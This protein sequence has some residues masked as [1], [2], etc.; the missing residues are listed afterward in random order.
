VAELEMQGQV[1]PLPRPGQLGDPEARSRC[2]AKFAHHELMAVELFAWALLRWPTLPRA[3][4]K[5]LL[6]ILTEE[7]LHC[8]LYLE[9]LEAHGS[10]LADHVLSDYFW[11]HAPAISASAE[12][13]SAFL[14]AMGLTLEQGNLD[15]GPLYRDAFRDAGDLESARVCEQVHRDEVAHVRF[16]AHW[17]R[18]LSDA[19]VDGE[20]GSAPGAAP[21][22][23]ALYERAVPFLLSAARAK[24]RRF[25]A[26]ARREAGLSEDF[27]EHVR[28]ARPAPRK[29]GA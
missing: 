15:F 8:R 27:I 2:L 19:G 4:Q 29:P 6:Q 12:G 22:D 14:A 25:N 11:K 13:P 7:Q 21:D 10:R 23:I 24:G 20:Q 5:G 9:R 18:A 28:T 26:D 3:M 17:L 1:E 16:A